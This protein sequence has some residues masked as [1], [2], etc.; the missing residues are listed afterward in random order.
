MPTPTPTS[1]AP[2]A[3][4]TQVGSAEDFSAAGPE[5]TGQVITRQP[6]DGLQFGRVHDTGLLGVQELSSPF[7][8]WE[9]DPSRAHRAGAIPLSGDQPGR[10]IHQEAVDGQRL[11]GSAKGL[12]DGA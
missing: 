6:R 5:L 3:I 1:A 2:P 8:G 10:Q 11:E 7:D 9:V 12:R 4:Q